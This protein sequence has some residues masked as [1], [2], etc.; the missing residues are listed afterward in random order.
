MY[1]VLLKLSGKKEEEWQ[2]KEGKQKERS[3]N[4]YVQGKVP[5][6]SCVGLI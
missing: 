4:F 1:L 6:I 5:I 3:R 2:R